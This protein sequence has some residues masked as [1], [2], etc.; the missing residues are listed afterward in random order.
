MLNVDAEVK[1]GPTG[2][3]IVQVDGRTVAVT[4]PS[5]MLADAAATALAASPPDDDLP[6]ESRLAPFGITVLRQ[7][8]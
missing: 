4:A 6:L 2:K 8:A 7:T 1:V 3:F 5:A